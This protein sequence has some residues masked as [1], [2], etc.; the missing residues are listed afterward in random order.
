MNRSTSAKVARSDELRRLVASLGDWAFGAG[1]L[2]RQLARAVAAAIESGTLPEGLRLP[3]ERAL[4]TALFLSRGTTVA[5]YDLLVADGLVER[6]QGSGTYVAGPAALGLPGGREGSALVHRLVEHSSS[7]SAVIDLSISVLH[8]AS[9]LP[10][11]S[12]LHA[13][14]WRPWSPRPATPP[15]ARP[16]SAACWPTTSPTGAC[17][18]APARS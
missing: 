1:P 11:V 3:S 14:T 8:D 15:G 5:A 10:P 6:R 2:F 7:R 16:A 18:P 9:G 4:S 17:P 12:R 13:P